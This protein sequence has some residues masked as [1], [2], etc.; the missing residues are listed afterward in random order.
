MKSFIA[1]IGGKRLLR[2]KIVALFPSGI[3][4]YIEV[5]GGAG[6]VLFHRDKH[7]PIEI[8][9][10]L[11]GELV[12]LFRCIKYHRGELQRELDGWLSSREFFEDFLAQRKVRGLTDIQRASRYFLSVKLSYGADIRTFGCKG[13]KLSTG[14]DYLEKVEQRLQGVTIEHRDFEP[15]LKTYDKPDA[16]SY[17]D[18]PY[19]GTEDYYSGFTTDDHARLRQCLGRVRGRFVLSYNDCETI[20]QMYEGCH[21][22]EVSRLNS[23]T[24]RYSDAEKNYKELLITNF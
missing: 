18:P 10:D 14:I 7:A 13:T 24:V 11:D 16:L 17:L 23:L 3:G 19:Y 22:H 6:W 8:Y 2:D 1:R 21:I 4:R 12:N 5:F 20:R 9:N 15:L